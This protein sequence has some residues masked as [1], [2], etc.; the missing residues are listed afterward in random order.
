MISNNRTIT[1]RKKEGKKRVRKRAESCDTPH[2]SDSDHSHE[3]DRDTYREKE[4]SSRE[5]HSHAEESGMFILSVAFVKITS[6]SWKR[7]IFH[8]VQ[9]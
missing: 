6:V 7:D 5:E 2:E 9:I 3:T 8:G 1:E 4:G